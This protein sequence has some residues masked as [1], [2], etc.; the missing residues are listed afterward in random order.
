MRVFRATLPKCMPV[1]LPASL[2]LMLPNLYWETTGKPFD[3]LGSFDTTF[4][5]LAAVGGL[6]YQWLAA[7]IMVRQHNLVEHRG[8]EVVVEMREAGRRWA[9]LVVTAVAAAAL[10]ALGVF[11]LVVPGIFA[12][13]CFSVLRPVVLFERL[14]ALQSLQRCVQ[15]VRPG[16]WKVC[17][18][19]VIAALTYVV[20]LLMSIV[21]VGL[22]SGAL[23]AVGLS[24]EAVKAVGS[25]CVLG[26]QAIALVYFSAL[27]LAIYAV[28]STHSVASSSA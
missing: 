19:A 25:A 3:L 28:V 5:V 7:I 15:L 21:V 22:L 17:A 8:A 11:T 2:L 27:W 24:P 1:A 10:I 23:G 26:V 18:A 16:W 12:A 13:V 4:W 9:L 14:G 6:A 20:C